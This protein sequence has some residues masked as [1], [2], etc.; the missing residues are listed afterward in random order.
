MALPL[1]QWSEAMD[2]NQLYH[3]HQMSLMRADAARMGGSRA[4]HR[5]EAS[6]IARQIERIHRASGAAALRNWEERYTS[7]DQQ[8][9]SR[10]TTNGQ[11]TLIH[12]H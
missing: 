4:L 8:P 6:T 3:D 7:T 2:L 12:A 9:G 11:P 10:R 5:D 1:T